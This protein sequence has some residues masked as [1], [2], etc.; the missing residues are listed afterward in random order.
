MKK[1]KILIAKFLGWIMT[2]RGL[3]WTIKPV[4]KSMLWMHRP[5]LIKKQKVQ[6]YRVLAVTPGRHR[7]WVESSAGI[8]KKPL[9]SI[10][11]HL[12]EDCTGYSRMQ[13]LQ[14]MQ[15]KTANEF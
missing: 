9:C 4:L 1:I 15:A 6:I 10:P 5:R 13:Y 14:F 3:R 8:I 2:R 7:A 12:L 11:A